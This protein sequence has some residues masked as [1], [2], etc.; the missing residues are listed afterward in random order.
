M[1]TQKAISVTEARATT[2]RLPTSA[3]SASVPPRE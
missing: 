1:I 2:R 3:P